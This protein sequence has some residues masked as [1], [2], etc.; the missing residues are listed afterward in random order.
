MGERKAGARRWLS[1]LL[2]ATGIVAWL[3]ML[4]GLVSAVIVVGRGFST[5]QPPSRLEAAVAGTLR[6]WSIPASDRRKVS[7]LPSTPEV[8][9]RARAHWADHC[10][11]CHGNDGS[12]KT[13][14]GERLYPR[15]PDMRGAATQ[16]LSD[17]EIFYI[18]ENGVRLTGMPGWHVDGDEGESWDLVAFVRH[19]PKLTATE[20]DQ[21]EKLNPKSP[22]DVKEEQEEQQFLNGE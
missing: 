4:V 2:T 6:R 7:P 1:R 11:I 8:L 22:E 5:R 12:G 18:I 10:A 20:L 15:A 13:E 17:G 19:L 3:G 16:A 9:A 21:M 14:V